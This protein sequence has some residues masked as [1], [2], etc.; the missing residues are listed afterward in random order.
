MTGRRLRGGGSPGGDDADRRNGRARRVI[1]PVLVTIVFIGV[2]FVG[3]FPTQ[4][5]LGQKD[6]ADQ[7]RAELSEVEARNARLQA[8][9]EALSDPAQ[10]ELLARRD[11]GLV[12]PGEEAYAIVPDAG[13]EVPVPD[14]YPFTRL[15]ERLT[16]D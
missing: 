12:F 10:L 1:W 16:G 8:E 2:L 9:V 13:G 11:F 14:A 4:T 5:Y 15:E 3:V 7:L 6:E